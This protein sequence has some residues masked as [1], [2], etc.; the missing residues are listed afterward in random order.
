MG[1]WW[2]WPWPT[3]STGKLGIEEEKDWPPTVG[4]GAAVQFQQN[5]G[6]DLFCVF[7]MWHV[8]IPLRTCDGALMLP[9]L[10]CS[11]FN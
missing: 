11:V 8:K 7:K 5:S 9:H 3:T 10:F 2:S 6:D 4:L 1:H